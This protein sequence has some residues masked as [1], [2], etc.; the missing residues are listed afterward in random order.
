MAGRPR[1]FEPEQV[2]DGAVELFWSRGYEGTRVPDLVRELGICRQSLYATFGDKRALF[3]CALERYGERR[4][5]PLRRL[6]EAQG[7]PL[8]NVRAVVQSWAEA[9]A[10][11][12]GG[13]GCMVVRAIAE[14]DPEDRELSELTSRLVEQLEQSFL[15]ALTRAQRAGELGGELAPQRLAGLLTVG[16]H[17]IAL[18]SRLPDSEARI[19]D[20]VGALLGLLEA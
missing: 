18:L 16:A 2:V 8:A 5:E 10:R 19:R 13:R 9:H 1:G 3:L 14:L 4:S 11:D 12:C 6:L 20:A 17:G 7:S 15:E